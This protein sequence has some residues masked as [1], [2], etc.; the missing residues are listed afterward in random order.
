MPVNPVEN[1][2]KQENCHPPLVAKA[3]N[4]FLTL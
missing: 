2:D 3:Q 1:G 4:S